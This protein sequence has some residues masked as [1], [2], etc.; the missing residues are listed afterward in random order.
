MDSY[1]WSRFPAAWFG[2]NATHWESPSQIAAIGKY[3]MAILGWQHLAGLDNMTAVVYA[4]LTQAAILKAANPTQAVHVYCSFGWA[5]GMN[6]AVWPLM[7]DERYAGFFLQSTGNSF[8]FSRTNCYQMHTQEKRCVG[9]FWNFGNATARDYYISR[10]VAPLAAAPAIDG[11]FFDAFNYAYDIPEVKPWGKPVINV[12]NCSTP[13]ASPG[14]AVRWDGCEALLNGTLDVARRATALLNAH[15]KTPIFANPASFVKPP[16][17]HI[18]LDEARLA[19]ALGGMRWLTYYESFRGDVDP[20]TDPN[21]LLNNMLTESKAGIASA[22]HTYYHNASEDPTPHVAAFLLARNTSWYFFGST[23]WWDNSFQW[24]SL[25]DTAGKCGK[26][27]GPASSAGT[28]A[29]A[30]LAPSTNATTAW[31]REFVGCRVALECSQAT[32]RCAGSI[33]LR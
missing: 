20:R 33:K 2:A 6:E 28:R 13:A 19:A 18:W 25:Y 31:Q 24:T 29:A 10:L 15:G 17:Q 1:D 23:G 8:E 27:L 21:G 4:Q 12:P 26:P 5:F 32:G 7:A 16:K 14:G 11:V 9:Y 30:G 3:A 22:V